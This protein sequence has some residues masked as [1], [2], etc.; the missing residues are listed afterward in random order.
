MLALHPNGWHF[1]ATGAPAQ[2]RNFEGSMT[3]LHTALQEVLTLHK[4]IHYVPG[5]RFNMEKGETFEIPQDVVTMGLG[6]DPCRGNT[7]M[8]LD[9]SVIMFDKVA[10]P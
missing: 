10:S 9:A 2:G 7:N 5:Q 4:L 3:E 8:D 6:W 1:K